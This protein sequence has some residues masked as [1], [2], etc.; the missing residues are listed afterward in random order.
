MLFDLRGRH[1]RRAVRVIYTGLA[2]LMGIGLVGFGVGGGF[3]G[4]GLLNAASNNEGGSKASFAAE[5]KKYDKI[6]KQQ[7][8]NVAAWE[9]LTLAQL[10]EA[11]GE[12]LVSNGQLTPK[13]K[14]LFS[15]AASSWR[16]YLALNP[17]KPS[18]Q[19][20][21]NMQRIFSE[22]G[23]NEPTAEVQVLQIEVAARPESAS[24][25]GALAVAAYKAKNPGVGDLAA[26]KAV[27]LAP[28]ADRLRL[29]DELKRLKEHP[30]G[31]EQ[32]ATSESGQAFKVKTSPSGKIT[33]APTGSSGSSGASGTSG[34]AK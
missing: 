26:A 30:N 5:I 25:F 12:A 18:S 9:K 13:G 14:E 17:P 24:L 33:A 34:R 6:T 1:R 27:S 22:E 31:T 16:S 7:P 10:H 32:A 15:E 19:L 4:G 21:A 8:A 3:G 29:K 11:G 20:A 23:L 2:L 28:A